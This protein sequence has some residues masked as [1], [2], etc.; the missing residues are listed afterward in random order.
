MRISKSIIPA[1][2]TVFLFAGAL[3]AFA[4]E[5]LVVNVPF[6]FVSG[7]TPFPPGSYVL[8]TDRVAPGTL[9]L[10]GPRNAIF[11]SHKSVSRKH[12]SQPAL[13]FSVHGDKRF[14]SRVQIRNTTWTLT[15]FPEEIELARTAEAAAKLVAQKRDVE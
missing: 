14:L 11:L 1:L 13:T 6:D 7:K 10:Q 5:S 15:P 8:S 4:G 2:L 9:M 12:E 3:H